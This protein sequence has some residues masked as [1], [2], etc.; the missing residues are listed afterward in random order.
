MLIVIGSNFHQQLLDERERLQHCF[1]ALAG[2]NNAVIVATCNRNEIYLHTTTPEHTVKAIFSF[3]T[4]QYPNFASQAYV[5]EDGQ[6]FH[7]LARV[8]SG[9]DSAMVG[10]SHIQHQVK[11]AYTTAL[12]NGKLHPE[13]HYIFQKSLH[14]G[15][16]VRTKWPHLFHSDSLPETILLLAREFF[17]GK[18]P[19][20]LFI[21]ASKINRSIAARLP[22]S[23]CYTVTNRTMRHLHNVSSATSTL[24]WEQLPQ[25]WQEYSWIIS[26][27]KCPHKLLPEHIGPKAD[28]LLIDLSVPRTIHPSADGHVY[29]IDELAALWKRSQDPVS[30]QFSDIEWFITDRIAQYSQGKHFWLS[31][32]PERWEKEREPGVVFKAADKHPEDA[33]DLTKGRK[34]GTALC[35]SCGTK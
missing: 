22:A 10:E 8:T 31:T 35:G 28:R 29:N 7:H 24:P 14:I 4:Q 3:I 27:V 30:A 17:H 34:E 23:L 2:C 32:P 19:P 9:L 5:Y 26:G 13:L 25:R 16:M 6:C 15:K 18:L 1:V 21:G 33:D 11:E 12:T 20:P